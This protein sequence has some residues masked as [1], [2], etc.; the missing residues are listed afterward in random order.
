MVVIEKGVVNNLKLLEY[1]SQEL[2]AD[3]KIPANAGIIIDST[4]ELDSK[5]SELTF[6]VVVKAQVQTGGRGKAGGIQFADNPNQ[7][8]DI[9]QHLLGSKIKDLTVRKLLIVNKINMKKEWYLSFTFDRKNKVP[10]LIFS[11]EGG[12]DIE[13]TA[14]T[15]PD[16][17]A[18]I[19]IDPLIGIKPYMV[20]YL[21]NKT[22]A[23]QEYLEELYKVL[24]NLYNLFIK[25]DCLLAEINPLVITE[26]QG[27]MAL[28][29]KIDIDNNSLFRH[30][31]ILEFREQ[32]T[33]N[34]LVKEARKFD[35]I[36]IP[37]SKQGTIGIISNGSG[38]IMST[39]DLITKKGMQV[40]CALDL[41]GG[42]TADRVEEAIRIV[43][44]NLNVK[45]LIINIF[46]GITRCD[47]IANGV[48]NALKKKA[49]FKLVIR[50]EGT[51][52]ELG[53]NIINNIKADII[54]V[55]GVKEGVEKLYE[56]FN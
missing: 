50:I 52:K 34:L 25:Q 20:R 37:I 12:V 1:K 48:K 38:M 14:R 56:H 5:L 36:Y 39:M 32:I 54:S 15:Q 53:L 44:E 6:P 16:K 30:P 29:A 7:L 2:F 21:I 18:R 11:S 19:L 24:K 47:E 8:K 3:Y 23:E 27:L 41:G 35:F 55:D 42:A 51:N 13:E 46:G 9:C 43:L 10:L 26:N 17:I 33:E 49:D 4:E 22:G 28:D 31:D 40:A 45:V